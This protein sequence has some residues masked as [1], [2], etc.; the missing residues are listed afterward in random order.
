VSE[1]FLVAIKPS[2]RRTNGAVGRTVNRSGTHHRFEFRV[3]AETWAAGLASRGGTP[4]W[5]REANPNDDTDVDAYLM[6]RRRTPDRT[7]GDTGDQTGVREYAT[8]S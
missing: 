8:D 7:R 1:E 5:I 3:D 6:G 2:A 4:V